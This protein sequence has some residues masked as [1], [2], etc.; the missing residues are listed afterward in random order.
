[1]R[2]AATAAAAAVEQQKASAA[3]A[4]PRLHAACRDENYVNLGNDL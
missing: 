4:L 1:M 3:A 2:W